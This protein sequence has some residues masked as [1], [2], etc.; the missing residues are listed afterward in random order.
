MTH[1]YLGLLYSKQWHDADALLHFKKYLALVPMAEN[2][3]EVEYFMT[4]MLNRSDL[5]IK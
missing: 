4:I 5:A 1:Y 3:K 2:R